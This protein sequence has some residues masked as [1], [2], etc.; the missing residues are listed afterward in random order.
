MKRLGLK[1]GTNV[2]AV[3]CTPPAKDSPRWTPDKTSS[4]FGKRYL[5][6]GGFHTVEGSPFRL[7]MYGNTVSTWDKSGLSECE[8][9]TWQI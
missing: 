2:L 6:Q 7:N 8:Y 3:A 1:R 9:D 4:A 5:G